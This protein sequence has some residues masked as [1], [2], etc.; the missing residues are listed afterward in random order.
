MCLVGCWITPKEENEHLLVGIISGWPFHAS[1][2]RGNLPEIGRQRKSLTT[3]ELTHPRIDG[4]F[5]RGFAKALEDNHGVTA[6]ILSCFPIV[7]DGAY[8]IASVLGASVSMQKLQLRE[9]RNHREIVTFFHS[10]SQN[11]SVEELSLRHSQISPRAANAIC[12]FLRT[13]PILKEIR[14]IDCQLLDDSLEVICQ[15]LKNNRTLLPR[16]HLARE[17]GATK[18]LLEYASN[19]DARRPSKRWRDERLMGAGSRHPTSPRLGFQQTTM[20]HMK[21]QRRG[22]RQQEEVLIF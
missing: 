8:A 15:G 9:L 22:V 11:S 18:I 7:D 4:L 16:L 2:A 1:L 14:L 5:A 13:H 17:A 10:L 3:V 21:L 12:K 6:L 19:D 20:F